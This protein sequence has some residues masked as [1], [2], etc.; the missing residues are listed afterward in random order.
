M[1]TI[2]RPTTS[3]NIIITILSAESKNERRNSF[4]PNFDSE[5]IE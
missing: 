3:D 2:G 4:D 1:L 5:F